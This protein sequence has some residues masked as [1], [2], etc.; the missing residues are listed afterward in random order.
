MKR[1]RPIIWFMTGR[2][3]RSSE[4]E[5]DM[6]SLNATILQAIRDDYKKRAIWAK[7][8]VVPGRDPNMWRY[9]VFWSV[10]KWTDYGDRSSSY[11]WELDHFPTPLA[12]GGSDDIS[13]LRPLHFANNASLGAG[14]GA[15]FRSSGGRGLGS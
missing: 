10:M 6:S 13:N 1:A 9:D 7:G 3:N 15:A 11:G 12:L 4:Q 14:L 2:E 8:I 5:T